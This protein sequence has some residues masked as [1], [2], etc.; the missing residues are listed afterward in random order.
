[1]SNNSEEIETLDRVMLQ[2]QSAYILAKAQSVAS[3]VQPSQTSME[4]MQRAL[5]KLDIALDTLD[6][7]RKAL[8]DVLFS[9][10]MKQESQDMSTQTKKALEVLEEIGAEVW[11]N[12]RKILY[13]ALDRKKLQANR[14][15][16]MQNSDQN[17]TFLRNKQSNAWEQGRKTIETTQ[18][19][20]ETK[21][22]CCNICPCS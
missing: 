13:D 4:E 1:M 22:K 18:A 19:T 17:L 2:A 6:K 3:R 21:R 12:E 14:K 20:K 11:R 10:M 9:M 8:Q 16:L 15:K 5:D 7:A